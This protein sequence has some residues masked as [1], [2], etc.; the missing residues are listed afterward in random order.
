MVF[1]S[2]NYIVQM[3]MHESVCMA[4]YPRFVYITGAAIMTDIQSKA[5]NMTFQQ[6]FQCFLLERQVTGGVLYTDMNRCVANCIGAKISEMCH[7]LQILCLKGLIKVDTAVG[8]GIISAAGHVH[9]QYWCMNF[10]CKA[11]SIQD[12]VAITTGHMG[13]KFGHMEFVV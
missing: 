3:Q 1:L 8:H 6:N 12:A 5:K 7:T 4:K 13:V 9:I 11:N 2:V 10:L